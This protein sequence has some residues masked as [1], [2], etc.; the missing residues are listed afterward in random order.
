[1]K[2]CGESQADVSPCYPVH[3]ANR[4]AR[5]ELSESP[6]RG[7]TDRQHTGEF[8]EGLAHPANLKAFPGRELCRG[9]LF[10]HPPT[11]TMVP[12]W[13]C[14]LQGIAKPE[15]LWPPAVTEELPGC[16]FCRKRS[17]CHQAGDDVGMRKKR[18][19]DDLISSLTWQR[20]CR[21]GDSGFLASQCPNK[22]FLFCPSSVSTLS[23][24]IFCS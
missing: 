9:L 14:F 6:G 13:V 7:A 16:W 17:P 5:L 20:F 11:Y 19:H 24:G 23:S 8:G 12:L 10:S 3:V 21:S 15:K 4:W 22:G 2:S 1:M 18:C